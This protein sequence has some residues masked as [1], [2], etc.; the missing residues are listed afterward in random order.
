MSF[1]YK[2]NTI[3]GIHLQL[4]PYHQGKLITVIKGSILDVVIDLR[5][6]SKTFKKIF[7][8][9]LSDKKNLQLFVPRGFGHGFCT[10]TDNTIVSY[11]VD[12][13]YNPNKEI[14]IN[15]ADLNLKIK[16]PNKNS[17]KILSKKDIDGINLRDYIE[18]YCA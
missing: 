5:K 8:F 16:W 6:N 2:K 14:S 15:Y 3:R 18:K 1:S 13:H 9:K 4:A 17:K 7:Y 11:K 10:L 12:N